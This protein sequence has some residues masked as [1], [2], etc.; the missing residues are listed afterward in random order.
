VLLVEDDHAARVAGARY[1]SAIAPGWPRWAVVR[2]MSKVLHP[3]LR[4]ALLAGDETTVAR[5]EGRQALGPRWVSHILQA[6]TAELLRDPSFAASVERAALAYADRRAELIEALAEHGIVAHG[7]SGL[8]VW[9]PVR[10]ESA[11]VRALLDAGWLVLAGE[12]FRLR[13]A[14]AVRITVA[15]LEPGEATAIAQVLAAAQ[16]RGRPRRA[17]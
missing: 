16:A 8:N 17:Y 1:V 5:L 7:R 9:V 14:P 3:D 6:T 12:R 10:E 11:T 4:V 15:T 2:T 13:S